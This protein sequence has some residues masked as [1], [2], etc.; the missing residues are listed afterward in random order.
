MLPGYAVTLMKGKVFDWIEVV[1][2]THFITQSIDA[3]PTQLLRKFGIPFKEC[4]VETW[5]SRVSLMNEIRCIFGKKA[6]CRIPVAVANA[7]IH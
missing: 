5:Y 7:T 2:F 6:N 1:I 3:F 4:R